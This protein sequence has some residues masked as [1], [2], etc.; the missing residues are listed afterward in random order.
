MQ[1]IQITEA[2]DK[3]KACNTGHYYEELWVVLSTEVFGPTN[4]S[5]DARQHVCLVQTTN[6]TSAGLLNIFYSKMDHVKASKQRR[7]TSFYNGP[8]NIRVS[9][10]VY[11]TQKM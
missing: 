1:F 3:G 11:C 7:N 6:V 10:C 9:M 4:I 5:P 8:F 2:F